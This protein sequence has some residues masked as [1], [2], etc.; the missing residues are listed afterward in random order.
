MSH[1]ITVCRAKY[2]KGNANQN[3]TSDPCGYCRFGPTISTARPAPSLRGLLL[4]YVL[5]IPL[6]ETLL[7]CDFGKLLEGSKP[8]EA[9]YQ[10][11]LCLS[12][13]DII[14]LKVRVTIK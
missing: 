2:W 9:R 11:L 10:A 4:Q 5:A 3:T 8:T 12:L 1:G 13:L 14:L 6:S 7:P